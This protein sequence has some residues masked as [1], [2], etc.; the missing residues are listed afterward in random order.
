LNATSNGER[1]DSK[2]GNRRAAFSSPA[3]PERKKEAAEAR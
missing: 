1:S 3:A 2:L